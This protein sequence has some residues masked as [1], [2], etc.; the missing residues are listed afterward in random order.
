MQR[1]RFISSLQENITI[2]SI[3]LLSFFLFPLYLLRFLLRQPI[4]AGLVDL[5]QIQPQTFIELRTE[6]QRHLS[7]VFKCKISGK[8]TDA[9]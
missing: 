9:V 7:V 5:F 2:C 8:R 3:H 4:E 6:E 1:I